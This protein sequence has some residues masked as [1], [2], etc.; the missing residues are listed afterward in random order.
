MEE[1]ICVTV[2]NF[3]LCLSKL[4]CVRF[5]FLN[6][7]SWGAIPSACFVRCTCALKYIIIIIIIII[8][9]IYSKSGCTVST[10]SAKDT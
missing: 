9:Y 10:Q 3:L 6:S 7:A 5:F 4:F 1:E 8:I 2:N